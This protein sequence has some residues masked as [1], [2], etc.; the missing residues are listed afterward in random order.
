M[1]IDA[2]L[3][4]MFNLL[5]YK[6]NLKTQEKDLEELYER[7]SNTTEP[8]LSLDIFKKNFDISKYEVHTH[9]HQLQAIVDDIPDHIQK[10]LENENK[11][12]KDLLGNFSKIKVTESKYFKP[13]D[14]VMATTGKFGFNQWQF[15]DDEIL[16]FKKGGDIKLIKDYIHTRSGP[17]FDPYTMYWHKKIKKEILYNTRTIAEIREDKLKQLLK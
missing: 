16:Y 9:N 5:P 15:D 11:R 12:L 13:K 10:M 17:F 1:T 3:V 6:I 2:V 4:A 8:I 14:K 7:V